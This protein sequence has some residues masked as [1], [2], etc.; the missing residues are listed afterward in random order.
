MHEAQTP[1]RFYIDRNEDRAVVR[2]VAVP[3]AHNPA[4]HRV[5]TPPPTVRPTPSGRRVRVGSLVQQA[6]RRRPR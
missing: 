5:D 6:I 2:T 3:S 1:R 4:V